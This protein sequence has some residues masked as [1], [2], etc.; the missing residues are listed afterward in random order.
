[1]SAKT[2]RSLATRK[3]QLS[4][5]SNPPVMAAP[6]IGSLALLEPGLAAMAFALGGAAY[7]VDAVLHR[8][9][10][11]HRA[12]AEVYA[13]ADGEARFVEE[14]AHAWAKVM[15]LDRFDVQ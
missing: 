5:S 12:L 1:M 8:A 11:P 13:S 4:A 3:S 14:F 2:A 7:L 10:E 9:T 6:L 15:D